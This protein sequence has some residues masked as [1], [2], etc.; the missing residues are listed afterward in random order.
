MVLSSPLG[1]GHFLE[2]NFFIFNSSASNAM[3]ESHIETSVDRTSLNFLFSD[4]LSNL[5]ETIR[6]N[7]LDETDE[8]I[9]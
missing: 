5:P 1:L 6:K 7:H 2:P 9:I 4:F 8:T 3:F